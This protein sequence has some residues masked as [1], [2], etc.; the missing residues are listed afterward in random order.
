VLASTPGACAAWRPLAPAAWE[1][2]T[3]RADLFRT[4]LRVTRLDGRRVYLEQPRWTTTTLHGVYPAGWP[5]VPAAESL[6]AIPRDSIVRVDRLESDRRR[7][8][9][10][11]AGLGVAG[12]AVAIVAR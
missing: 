10:Y 7:T 6:L 12:A 2:A 1:Q 5:A 4:R 11:L 8:A 3:D 9:L